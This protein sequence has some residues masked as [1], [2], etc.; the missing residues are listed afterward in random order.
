MK[1]NE[2]ARGP[3]ISRATLARQID[4]RAR[5]V[6]LRDR[7]P[8]TNPGRAPR[9]TRTRATASRSRLGQI[10]ARLPTRVQ[11][12]GLR[13]LVDHRAANRRHQR[14]AAKRAALVAILEAADIAMRDQRRQRHAA[15]ETFGQCHDIRRDVRV[16]ETEQSP[17]AADAGL[18]F[19]EDQQQ[20]P[21]ARQV[22]Q[23]AQERARCLE[24]TGLALDRFQHHGDRSRRDRRRD[25][26][27]II[28]RHLHE[29]RHLRFV[30]AAPT[31]VFPTPPSWPACGRENRDPW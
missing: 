21:L 4:D 17:G 9:R 5:G 11:E 22:A 28:Q 6:P 14:I 10:R 27:E 12:A 25:R 30:T 18:N 13:D 2:S 20:S 26:V 8:A 19:V 16:L 3:L 23:T 15:T 29:S 24:N 1:R 31:G 7:A